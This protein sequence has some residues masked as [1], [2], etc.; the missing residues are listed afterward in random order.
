MDRH[1]QIC[2]DELIRISET[3]PCSLKCALDLVDS[4]VL[5]RGYYAHASQPQMINGY[6]SG[7]TS[8]R[9]AFSQP[10]FLRDLE[11]YA[12]SRRKPREAA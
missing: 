11:T 6:A 2:F 8:G 7:G 10:N 3:R 12:A 1:L 4:G 5:T 9:R